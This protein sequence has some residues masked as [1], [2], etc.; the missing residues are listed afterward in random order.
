MKASSTPAFAPDEVL[1]ELEVC[2]S[3]LQTNAPGTNFCRHC[4]TPLTSYAA[5]APL[6]SIF[7]EGNFWRKAVAKA[8]GHPLTRVAI[9]SFL[10]LMM[11]ALLAG[12][13][14]PR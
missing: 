12:M 14:T 6:E 1:E 13:I 5:T 11:L 4:G 9:V 3:C 2:I 8:K 7:A 10:V